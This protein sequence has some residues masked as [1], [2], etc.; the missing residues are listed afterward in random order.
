MLLKSWPHSFDWP[1]AA[2]QTSPPTL[3]PSAYSAS[4]TPASLFL[5]HARRA[6]AS[7]PLHLCSPQRMD[8]CPNTA[9]RLLPHLRPVS[10]WTPP[11]RKAFSDLAVSVSNSPGPAPHSR[12]PFSWAFTV[13]H[14]TSMTDHI[15]TYCLLILHHN[16]LKPISVILKMW[17]REL[18]RNCRD[19]FMGFMSRNHA[20]IKGPFSVQDGPMNLL[21]QSKKNSLKIRFHV[22]HLQLSFKR[23]PHG[24]FWSSIKE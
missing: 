16:N 14:G 4:N 9:A 1:W 3:C 12:S 22:S 15:F 7:E 18:P 17:S 2:F 20:W 21:Q 23:M 6:A 5:K 13:P 11:Y 24:Q 8:S 19:P 10:P